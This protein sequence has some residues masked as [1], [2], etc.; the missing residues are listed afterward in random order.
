MNKALS[1]IGYWGPTILT[2]S[3]IIGLYIHN[4]FFIKYYAL[5]QGL[6]IF[7]ILF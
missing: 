4:V 6:N 7:L 2:V 1:A 5:F 3:T